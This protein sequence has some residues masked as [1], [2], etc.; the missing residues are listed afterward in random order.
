MINNRY[1]VS[2]KEYMEKL[3]ITA[4]GV[5]L[6]KKYILEAFISSKLKN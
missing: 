2:F 6:I 1:F 5:G 4:D 3:G